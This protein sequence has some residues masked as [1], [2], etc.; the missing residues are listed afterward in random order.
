M[1]PQQIEKLKVLDPDGNSGTIQ[2]VLLRDDLNNVQFSEAC[3]WLLKQ[4]L[5][6]KQSL[7]MENSKLANILK[8]NGLY[9][10]ENLFEDK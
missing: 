7:Q 4:T 2:S 5:Q 1:T 6:E 10:S 9:T 8:K 3:Y